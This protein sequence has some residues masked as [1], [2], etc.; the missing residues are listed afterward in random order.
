VT[1]IAHLATMRLFA[2]NPRWT[3]LVWTTTQPAVPPTTPPVPA[4][5]SPVLPSP[6]DAAIR[7]RPEFIKSIARIVIASQR[8]GERRRD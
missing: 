2:G 8:Y 3:R 1:A 6:G 4:K 7:A 5:A